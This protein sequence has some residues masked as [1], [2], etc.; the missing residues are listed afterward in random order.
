MAVRPACVG[1][2]REK[3]SRGVSWVGCVVG[4]RDQVLLEMAE[5]S[6]LVVDLGLGE[7]GVV[8]DS[9]L[10]CSLDDVV[11]IGRRFSARVG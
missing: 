9:T 10:R 4:E 2:E 8:G 7:Q 11:Q 3:S 6:Q 5:E 1:A